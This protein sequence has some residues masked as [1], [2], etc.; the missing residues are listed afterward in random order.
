ML[1]FVPACN[2][3]QAAKINKDLESR[4]ATKVWLSSSCSHWFEG[5]GLFA[6]RIRAFAA[7]RV[8]FLC[9]FELAYVSRKFSR[10][11]RLQ[12]ESAVNANSAQKQYI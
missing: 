1:A 12:L 2:Y 11:L 5:E 4:L 7:R 10:N 3:T 9:V 6:T 8:Q